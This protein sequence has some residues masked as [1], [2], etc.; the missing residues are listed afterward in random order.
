MS[1][2]I[3]PTYDATPQGVKKVYN[4]ETHRYGSG[5][6]QDSSFADTL[7]ATTAQPASQ[8]QSKEK[9]PPL[10]EPPRAPSDVAAEDDDPQ[11]S[12]ILDIINPLQHIPVIGSI[13]REM[14]GDTIKPAER[15]VGD[16]LYGA[17]TGT[18]LIAGIASIASLAV[19]QQTGKE[20]TILV[21]DA[22]FGT[23]SSQEESDS[24]VRLAAASTPSA[25]QSAKQ[26]LASN[27]TQTERSST[28]SV[29]PVTA[30]PLPLSPARV[31]TAAASQPKIIAPQKLV[32][33]A[34]LAQA[35]QALTPM[36]NKLYT[37]KGAPTGF[38]ATHDAKA[39]AAALAAN[40]ILTAQT[41]ANTL[42]LPG[43]TD[44]AKGG[45]N[46][47]QMMQ[48]SA[49]VKASGGTLPPALV[50]DMMLMALDKYKTAGGQ[51]PSEM[52]TKELTVN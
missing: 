10:V 36:G 34:A 40:P 29:Q 1:I 51:A 23:G 19:E 11:F 22:L 28:A 33:P 46:L 14:T 50:R 3:D 49:N 41:A 9:A 47:G 8:T 30:Q 20:P 5:Q 7:A 52:K 31:A 16:L 38:T 4:F 25:P 37:M 48:Q 17:A 35:H 12:D 42:P 39:Q 2:I 24:D 13:Y 32:P 6:T 26:T 15:V 45:P 44:D 21:A 43:A 27:E 18:I